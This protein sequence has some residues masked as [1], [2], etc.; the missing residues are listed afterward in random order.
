MR[1]RTLRKGRYLKALTRKEMDP[2]RRNSNNKTQTILDY[3]A[4]KNLGIDKVSPDETAE[5]NKLMKPYRGLKKYVFVFREDEL[6]N[7]LN[8]NYD[9]DKHRK[10]LEKLLKKEEIVKQL[11]KTKKGPRYIRPKRYY[12]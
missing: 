8:N 12:Y 9:L 3:V 7:A 1:R 6:K 2:V 10:R 11:R 5:F 4:T